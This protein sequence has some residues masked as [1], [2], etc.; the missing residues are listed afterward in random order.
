LNAGNG[1]SIPFPL[2]MAP[3]SLHP[4]LELVGR[5]TSH[6]TRL[7]LLL[8]HSLGVPCPLAPIRDLRDA[9]PDTY[10][11][12]PA[13]KLPVLRHGSETVFGSLNICRTLAAHPAATPGALIIWPED[14]HNLVARNAWE[15]LWHGMHAQ[16]QLA[17]GIAVCGL[18][19]GNAYFEKARA[20]LLGVLDWLDQ[21]LDGVLA[22]LPEQR[23][24]SLFEAALFCLVEHLEVRPTVS[25][26]ELDALHEFAATFGA[27]DAARATAYRHG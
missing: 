14:M 15:L 10:A 5:R 11:G 20:G 6:F 9:R 16:V 22:T 27:R 23:H 3:D 8:A 18:P 24:I 13:L 4:A 17:M 12:N 2:N 25:I 7:P 1:K 19:H 21:N 26:T